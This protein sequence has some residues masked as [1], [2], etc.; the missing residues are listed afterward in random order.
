MRRI[1][2]DDADL[3]EDQTKIMRKPDVETI[4]LL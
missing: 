4:Q 3:L 2:P 1:H